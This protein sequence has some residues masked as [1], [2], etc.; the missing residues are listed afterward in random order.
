[1]SGHY[2]VTAGKR[3]YDLSLTGDLTWSVSRGGIPLGI[4]RQLASGEC[5]TISLSGV[6][7]AEQELLEVASE[8]KKQEWW[9]KVGSQ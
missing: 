3:R 9:R 8:A 2:Q 6:E 4:V 5:E 1:M 7:R